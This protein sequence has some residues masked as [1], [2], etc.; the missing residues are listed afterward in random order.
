VRA[1]EL[2]ERQARQVREA[3]LEDARAQGEPRPVE[4]HVAELHERE[5]EAPCGRAGET[6]LAR[7]LAEREL[8]VLAVEGA[9]DRQAPR[10]GLHVVAARAQGVGRLGRRVLGG[11]L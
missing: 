1:G 5:E 6:G 11:W 7:D 2:R 10:E 3:E 4:A 8:A 9:D